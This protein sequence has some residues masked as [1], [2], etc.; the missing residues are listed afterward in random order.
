MDIL[1]AGVGGQGTIL[2]SKILAGAALLHGGRARTGETIGM[3]QRGGC[4][5]SHV[6]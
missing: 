2:A 3:S 5:V 4:V 1:I 6:R